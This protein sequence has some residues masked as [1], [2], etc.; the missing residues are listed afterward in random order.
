[1]LSLLTTACCI[2]SVMAKVLILCSCWPCL[3]LF[4]VWQLSDL[5]ASINSTGGIWEWVSTEHVLSAHVMR[6]T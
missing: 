5:V 4:A 6:A 1:V 3:F 2:W